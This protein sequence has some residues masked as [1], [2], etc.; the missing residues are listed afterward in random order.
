MDTVRTML[1]VWIIEA[2]AFLEAS[3][4]F[5]VG[6]AIPTYVLVLLSVTKVQSKAIPCCTVV[7]NANQRLVL[8]VP[9]LLSCSFFESIYISGG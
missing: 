6:I 3:G 4:I 8:C 5:P 2:S 9:V 7:R 1:C